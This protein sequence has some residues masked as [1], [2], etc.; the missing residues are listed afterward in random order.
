MCCY[1]SPPLPSPPLPSPPPPVKAHLNCASLS[2]EYALKY[3]S[4]CRDLL[5]L[6]PLRE[7]RGHRPYSCYTVARISSV[8]GMGGSWKY[9]WG[10]LMPRLFTLESL[11]TRL[12]SGLIV[13]LG[14]KGVFLET[15]LMWGPGRVCVPYREVSSFQG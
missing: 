12:P 2:H 14:I 3:N 4:L 8:Y 7:V 5:P 1:T 15:P 13:L 10:S 9:P 6:L 11:G